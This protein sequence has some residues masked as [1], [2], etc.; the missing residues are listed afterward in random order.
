[1]ENLDLSKLRFPSTSNGHREVVMPTDPHERTVDSVTLAV[2][3]PDE[4]PT[5]PVDRLFREYNLLDVTPD[6]AILAT[7]KAEVA[8]L[9]EGDEEA[10]GPASMKERGYAMSGGVSDYS[11]IVKEEYNFALRGAAGLKIFDEMRRS[12]AQVRSSLRLSKTPVIAGKWYVVPASPDA[13]DVEIAQFVDWNLKKS[14][15]TSWTQVLLEALLMLDFGSYLFEKVYYFRDWR[16]QQRTCWRKWAPRHPVDI[17]E[18]K[19]DRN[20]GL[21]SITQLPNASKN[22]ST[23][24]PIEQ[25]L[26]FSFDKEAGNAAGISLLRSAY[27]NWFYKKTL[28]KIDAIQK[29]R[30]GIGVP[31]IKMPPNFDADDKRLA[32]ELGSNLRTNEKAYVTVTPGWEVS[33]IELHGNPVD[34]I[35]SIEHHN[36]QIAANVLAGFLDE[37]SGSSGEAQSDLFLKS[38]RF[39][40]DIIRDVVNKYAIPELV[41]YNYPDVEDYPELRVR[42]I[43]ETVD[44][45]TLS[46]ALRNLVGAKVIIPDE[47]LEVWARYEM[48]LP[49]IDLATIRQVATPQLPGDEDEDGEG[50][51]GG[52]SGAPNPPQP[53]KVGLPRQAPADKARLTP[54]VGRGDS[55]RTA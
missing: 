45:R 40:A 39:I 48:D 34:V 51:G 16:G 26:V 25:L 10:R 31:L 18:W 30:H 54:G 9:A 29:E 21:E 27:Q 47:K 53:P 33:F 17:E 37:G 46:M 52:E 3:E 28:Y 11:G 55:P 44:W 19:Y 41:D 8:A 38:S 6:G 12:D 13:Q 7:S 2:N 24:I 4:Y 50:E 1:M 35:R 15:T 42:R 23:K 32:R 43:G 5:I 49:E 14:M 20:G 22:T 36:H